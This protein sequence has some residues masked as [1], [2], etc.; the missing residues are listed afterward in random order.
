[1]LSPQFVASCLSTIVP[2]S[3]CLSS[4]CLCAYARSMCFCVYNSCVL[5]LR[6]AL[7]SPAARRHTGVPWRSGDA[8][9]ES[10]PL[11]YYVERRL[12]WLLESNRILPS[13]NSHSH[14]PGIVK[15]VCPTPRRNTCA[16]C[17]HEIP[18]LPAPLLTTML[19]ADIILRFTDK[20]ECFL[21]AL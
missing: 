21:R 19:R 10:S 13:E 12:S 11:W 6:L 17:V 1:M 2:A 4:T 18:S 20:T 9:R 7:L 3:L 16:L 15:Y 14:C 8:C 5:S